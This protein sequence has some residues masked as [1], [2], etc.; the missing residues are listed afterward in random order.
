[1]A[2]LRRKLI[3]EQIKL[4]RPVEGA[5]PLDDLSIAD[6]TFLNELESRS[7]CPKCNKSRKYFCYTCYVPVREVEGKIPQLELPCMVDIIKH[8]KEID[9]KSTAAHAAIIAPKHVQIYTYP[10]IPEYSA[11]NKVILAFPS[12]EAIKL[13]QFLD[14]ISNTEETSEKEPSTKKA[15]ILPFEKVVFIDCTWNQTKRIYCDERIKGLQCVKLT[16]QNTLFW[17]Y[18][19]GKPKTYLATIEAIYY[20]M[21]EIHT[22]IL[23]LPYTHQYDNLLFFFKFMIDKINDV[24][25]PLS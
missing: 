14:T 16:S 13:D 11:S 1:M 9:G 12:N 25:E 20:F 22:K 21:V 4:I 7:E 17:R 23:K 10:N 2:E 3:S 8:P 15:K 24:Y 19:K 18:Q 5:G 6:S